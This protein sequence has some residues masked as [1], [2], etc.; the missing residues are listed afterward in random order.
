M[1]KL[2]EQQTILKAAFVALVKARKA[3]DTWI[4]GIIAGKTPINKVKGYKLAKTVER[5]V[6]ALMVA[7]KP[8]AYWR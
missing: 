1:T 3:H 5:K 7:L 2:T 8:F 4:K 6:L